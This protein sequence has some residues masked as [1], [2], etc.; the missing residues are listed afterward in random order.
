[1]NQTPVRPDD[2]PPDPWRERDYFR[3]L[4]A[5][6]RDRRPSAGVY[7]GVRPFRK[8]LPGKRVVLFASRLNG[9]LI[10]C[11]SRLEAAHCLRLEFDRT[12]LA[13]Q[14]QPIRLPIRAGVHLVPDFAVLRSGGG[15]EVH[16][17]KTR[18]ACRR[19]RIECRHREIHALLAAWSIPFRVVSEDTILAEPEASNLKGIY[20]CVHGDRH[21]AVIHQGLNLLEGL[22]REATLQS[23]RRALLRHRLPAHLAEQLL[24]AGLARVD[25]HR[26]VTPDSPIWRP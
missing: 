21:P 26:P 1:M 2:G 20:R 18:G 6:F 8:G 24:L 13:Y 9:G 5:M 19:D 22:G 11:E 10:P 14:S 15:I 16:E 17:V 7:Q 25:L 3:E 4:S 12:V 23:F